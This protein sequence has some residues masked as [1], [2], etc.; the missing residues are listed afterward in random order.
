MTEP[1]PRLLLATVARLR[2]T[3]EHVEVMFFESARIYRLERAAQ[4]YDAV[5]RALRAAAAS[6][7]RVQVRVTAPHGDAIDEVRLL[8]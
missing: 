2:P 5:L 1:D 6:G 8:Q 4:E 7:A 3:A